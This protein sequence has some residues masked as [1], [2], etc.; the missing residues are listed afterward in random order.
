MKFL[1][2]ILVN[3]KFTYLLSRCW[4]SPAGGHVSHYVLGIPKL[5]VVVRLYLSILFWDQ[6]EFIVPRSGAVEGIAAM[7]EN[8]N[9]MTAKL[10]RSWNMAADSC[11]FHGMASF[12]A[13]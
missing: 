5:G 8:L 11:Q 4:L 1:I 12:T 6:A 13:R 3:E 9:W 10:L 2:N 7:G